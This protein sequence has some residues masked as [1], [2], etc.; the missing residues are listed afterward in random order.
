MVQS[1]CEEEPER[2][3]ITIV[4]P[5]ADSLASIRTGKPGEGFIERLRGDLDWIILMALRKDPMRRYVSV[6]Q[7]SE[8]IHKYMDGLPVIARSDT[9][10]TGRESFFG[11]TGWPSSPSR[12]SWSPSS[13]ASFPPAANKPAPK[14]DSMTSAPWP[15]ASCSKSATR[16]ATCPAPRRPACSSSNAPK[17][18]SISS[19][20]NPA[21]IPR[22]T[23]ARGGVQEGRRST[24]PRRLS[25]PRR[26][27]WRAGQCPERTGAP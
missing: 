7:F 4:R 24:I 18:I 10:P 21:T 22:S 3:S 16:F 8:D 15:T 11:A 20:T 2:P 17:L 26:Y 13:E 6:E 25:E 23:R 5:R 12:S 27:Q 9:F 19:T 14:R 1:I